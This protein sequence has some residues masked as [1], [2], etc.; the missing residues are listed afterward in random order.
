MKKTGITL[1]TMGA[2]NVLVL[3][4]TLQSLSTVCDEIVYGDMLLFDTDRETLNYYQ[5]CFNLK[6]VQFKFDYLFVNGFSK[7]LNELSKH[8]T[9]DI[10]VY[11]NT[12]E[13]IEEDYGIVETIK[14]NPECN[15][16]YFIHRTDPHR[17]YR[18]Y[19][20]KE[21]SWS[22]RIHEQLEGEYKPYHKPIFMMKDLEKDMD[23]SFKAKVF[24]TCKE[25]VYFKNYMAIIDN[26]NEL[27]ATDAGWIKFATENYNS[28]KERLLNKGEAYQAYLDGDLNS[29]MGYVYNNPEFGHQKFESNI[30][31][32]YQQDK[33]FLL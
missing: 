14:G 33:K 8:A 20:R 1:L 7:L 26:P 24:D 29:L 19:N 15:T 23:S 32:E 16:F 21:L 11:M 18:C 30:G 22:G 9:N 31:I 25:I 2:G 3:C 13:V 27:G 10:V 4:K 6:I 17:W 28:F 12:S 5:K